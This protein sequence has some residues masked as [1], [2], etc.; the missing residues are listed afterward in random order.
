MRTGNDLKQ[1]RSCGT[2]IQ[3][4]K[5]SYG[6]E[7]CRPRGR[8]N[9]KPADQ[10]VVRIGNLPTKRSYESKTCRPRCQERSGESEILTTWRSCE[11]ENSAI[12]GEIT[13]ESSEQ[14]ELERQELGK[15]DLESERAREREVERIR[16][17]SDLGNSAQESSGGAENYSRP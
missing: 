1:E 15:R 14:Q 3:P 2:V 9:W 6:T 12:S 4:T 11:S 13:R 8:T 17:F 16:K 5:R 10:E 7:T